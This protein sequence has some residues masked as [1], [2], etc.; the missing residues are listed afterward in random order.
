MDGT[1]AVKEI[2]DLD[3]DTVALEARCAH[4]SV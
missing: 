3:P 1:A 2:R 4:R